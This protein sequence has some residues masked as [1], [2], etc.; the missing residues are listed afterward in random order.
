M[1]TGLERVGYSSVFA[2]GPT[3]SDR[4][5]RMMVMCSMETQH[6]GNTYWRF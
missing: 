1:E 4:E 2:N 6:L 3:G 5:A